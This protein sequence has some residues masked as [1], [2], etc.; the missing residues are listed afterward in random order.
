VNFLSSAK[1]TN[2]NSGSATLD[3]E[4]KLAGLLFDSRF[5]SVASDFAELDIT[6]SIYV[7]MRFVLFVLDAVAKAD[8]LLAEL[9]VAPSTPR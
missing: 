6:R 4:G 1:S 3:A 7:D 5:D 2:G 8:A 9:G